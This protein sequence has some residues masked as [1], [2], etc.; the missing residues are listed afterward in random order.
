MISYHRDNIIVENKA[1]DFKFVSLFLD[2][3]VVTFKAV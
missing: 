1:S 3:F 2:K